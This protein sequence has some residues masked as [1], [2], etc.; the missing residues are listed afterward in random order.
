MSM[1][2]WLMTSGNQEM[3]L[4]DGFEDALVGYVERFG[5][6]PVAL[7]DREKCIEILMTRDGMDHDGAEEFFCVNVIGAWLGENTP[8]FASLRKSDE[9]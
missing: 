7:Y 8:A 6:P 4:A 1:Q 5:Q 9:L 2:G 3:L